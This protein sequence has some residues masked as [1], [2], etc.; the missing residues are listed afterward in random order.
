MTFIIIQHNFD[1]EQE[2]RTAAA[3]AAD[4]PKSSS[5]SS[6]S[7]S[8]RSSGSGSGRGQQV[9]RTAKGSALDVGYANPQLDARIQKGSAR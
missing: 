1:Y 2:P 5:G 4:E 7:S 9:H 3:A 6:S 8:S